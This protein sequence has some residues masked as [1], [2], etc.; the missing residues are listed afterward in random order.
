VT[1][2]LGLNTVIIAVEHATGS[3]TLVQSRN[4][5]LIISALVGRWPES[6]VN[7]YWET[8]YQIASMPIE[9]SAYHRVEGGLS[10]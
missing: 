9:V 6:H 7:R 2:Q 10:A 8:D 5:D 4:P 1:K 3:R